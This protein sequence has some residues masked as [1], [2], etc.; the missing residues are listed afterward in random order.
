[1][2]GRDRLVV[3]DDFLD[4]ERQ[5]FLGEIGVELGFDREFAERAT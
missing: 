1:M 4:D 5:K 3:P 2:L